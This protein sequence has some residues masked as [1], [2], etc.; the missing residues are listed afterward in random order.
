MASNRFA[1]LAPEFE[2]E[3]AKRKQAAEQKAKKEA[4][5]VKAE[6]KPQGE[7]K[8]EGREMGQPQTRGTMERGRARGYGRP[9]RARGGYRGGAGMGAP[10]YVPKEK[11]GFH[12]DR[13]FHFTGSNDPVHPFDRKSGTGRGTE[14]PKGGAGKGNWGN[15]EDDIK[16][17]EKLPIEEPHEHVEAHEGEPAAEAPKEGAEKKP[18]VVDKRQ[19]KREKKLRK[20]F[21]KKEEEEVTQEVYD[22]N[23]MTYTEYK[24]KLA[25][26]QVG[27]PTKKAEALNPKT[28]TG[29]VAYDKPQL[30]G[31][32][33]VATKKKEEPK[34]KEVAPAAEAK[35]GILGAFIGE[36][37]RGGF[38]G[39]RR[40]GRGGYRREGESF[41]A[42]GEHEGDHYRGRGGRGRGRG[43]AAQE[44]PR[45]EK[46]VERAAFVMKEDEFPTL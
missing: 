20:K 36:E 8:T 42:E 15:P 33:Q 30:S 46:K 25:E 37:A 26:M 31:I 5:R 14:I 38:R 21:G 29:L 24:A 2:E 44:Q 18:E 1:A 4:Q 35:P 9:Y 22:P 13:D 39:G 28:L 6:E 17:V 3:E 41:P 11:Q 27:L 19:A 23:A 34:E 43:F 16:N 7:R 10:T 40:G 45:E 32:S 12:D